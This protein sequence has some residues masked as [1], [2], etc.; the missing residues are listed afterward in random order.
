M[1][2]L[3]W[4][5]SWRTPWLDAFFSV[6]TELGG[7]VFFMAVAIIFFWCSDKGKGRASILTRVHRI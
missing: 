4:I 3:Y 6:I 7:E 2:L 5:E 1:S